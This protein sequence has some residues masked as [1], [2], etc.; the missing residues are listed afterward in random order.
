[1]AKEMMKS[2]ALSI[3]VLNLCMYIIVCATAGWALN[4]AIDHEIITGE[5]IPLPN[6]L[7]AVYFP[8]GNAA[9]GFFIIFA[10]IAGVVGGASCLSGLHYLGSRTE[11]GLASAVSAALTAWGLTLLAM[12][13]A[14]KEIDLHGRNSRLKTVESFVIILSVTQLLYVLVVIHSHR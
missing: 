8:M 11:N 6:P 9:T 12:G 1:M 3:L 4:K 14:W 7:W 13:L 10:L 2:V 5:G